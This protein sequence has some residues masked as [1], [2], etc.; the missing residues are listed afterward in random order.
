MA[1]LFR[2]SSLFLRTSRAALRA[3]TT[4]RIAVYNQMRCLSTEVKRTIEAVL[5]T[6]PVV[7][8]MKGTPDMPQCGFS[9]AT[10]QIL[11]LQGVDPE[12][13]TAFNV[14]EDEEVRQGIKEFSSWPT[15]PQLYINKEFIGGCDILVNMHS[16]GE[17][18]ELLEKEGVLV[19]AAPETEEQK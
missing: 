1:S 3:P 12:K 8:F 10:V 13:F 16:S 4:P 11:G 15:I 18:A 19:P 7:L 5:S 17:L 9:K 2:T 14:L 6:A